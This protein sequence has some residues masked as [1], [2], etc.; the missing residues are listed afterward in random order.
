MLYPV[1]VF[2]LVFFIAT[3]ASGGFTLSNLLR[4]GA[5]YG[6]LIAS[7]EWQRLIICIFLH[8]NV[9]HLFL[10]TYALF[11]LGRIVEGVYGYRKFFIAYVLSG[12]SGSVLSFLL[13]FRQVGV[14]ASGAIFG[15]AGLLFSGGLKYRNTSL[16]R[17][18]MSLLPF[19]LINLLIGFT[20][21]AI[22]NAAHVGGL[23][24]GMGLGWVVAPG[25]SIPSWK[26]F[27]ERIAYGVCIALVA[28]S[29]ASFFLPGI[30]PKAVS[31]E[32]VV[33]FHN[34]VRDILVGID[35]GVLPPE[36]V[37]RELRPPDREA[38]RIK[39]LLLAFLEEGDGERL[40]EIEETFLRW[41][42]TILRKYEGVVFESA[43]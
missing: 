2:N 21:P 10:N 43:P 5:K 29:V 41:R 8:G 32:D 15:L 6:P 13:N 11:Q 4:L 16:H 3:V 19:I 38:Q 39:D 40:A 7:G 20:V 25:F 12:L 28:L 37:V 34:N 35:R 36:Y 26:R 23:L 22:D 31:L 14:G 1:V 30:S 18:G 9:W 24:A 33:A 27:G 42:R 17:L